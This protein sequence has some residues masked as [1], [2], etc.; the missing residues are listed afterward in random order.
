MAVKIV[1][2]IQKIPLAAVAVASTAITLKS[3]YLRVSTGSTGAY[4][5]IGVNPSATVNSYHI[6]ANGIDV[7]KERVARQRIAGVVTGTATTVTF[8]ENAG[9]PFTTSDYVSFENTSIVGLNTVHNS[10][11]S[12][13]DYS[14]TVNFD[15][16]SYS[17]VGIA[18]T[19]GATVARSIKI[20]ALANGASGEVNLVE[21]Q[22]ASQ[23]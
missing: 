4:V 21:V 18:L 7:F 13:T 19:T 23:A 22:I 8:S 17:A 10:V 15:S 11:T 14:L 12:A 2:N 20:S 3:G 5:D 16:R 6:P 9:N 1:Q